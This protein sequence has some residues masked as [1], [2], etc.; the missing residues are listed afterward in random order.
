M[1]GITIIIG[2]KN[3]NKVTIKLTLFNEVKM[4]GFSTYLEFETV[5]MYL[6]H[7]ILNGEKQKKNGST[8]T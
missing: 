1:Y 6:P 5:I 2:F 3:P 8:R 4:Y 7:S